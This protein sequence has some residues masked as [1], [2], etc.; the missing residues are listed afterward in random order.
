[1]QTWSAGTDQKVSAHHHLDREQPQSRLITHDDHSTIAQKPRKAALHREIEEWFS[2]TTFAPPPRGTVHADSLP[3]SEQLS[4]EKDSTEDA[5][6]IDATTTSSPPNP[7]DP[8]SPSLVQADLS[9]HSQVQ[10]KDW[11]RF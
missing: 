5:E 7:S 1:M 9:P 11:S 10:A 8:P 6:S 2:G 3:Q 4:E